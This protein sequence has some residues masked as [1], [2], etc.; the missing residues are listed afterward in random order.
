MSADGKACLRCIIQ[1]GDY[2]SLL[3]EYI[4]DNE[5]RASVR[6]PITVNMNFSLPG[7]T[8]SED[9]SYPA[10]VLDLSMSGLCFGWR[11]C[12]VCTEYKPKTIHEKCILYPFFIDNEDRK[13]M[14]LDLKV[15]DGTISIDAFAVYSVKDEDEGIEY[16]G[17]KFTD[18]SSLNQRLIEKLVITLGRGQE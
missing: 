9:G 15:D 2:T 1:K 8:E 13:P 12:P 6:I 4:P 11:G 3:N 17:T 10:Y 7:E 5:R 14:N 18:L 16:I